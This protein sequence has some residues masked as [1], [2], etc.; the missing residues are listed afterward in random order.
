MNRLEELLLLW[1]DQSISETEL[2]ELK[3]LL[4]EPAARAQL[5]EDFMMTGVLVEALRTQ[6][7]AAST[8]SVPPRSRLRRWLLWGSAAAASLLAAVLLTQPERPSSPSVPFA[9]VE[10]VQGETFVV[11]KETSVPARA[12]QQLTP[13][14]GI[15]TEGQESEAVVKLEDDIRL[16]LSGDTTVFTSADTPD[17][18]ELGTH[19]AF[20][21]G[22]LLVEA[23]TARQRKLTVA[24][25]MGLAIAG[26]DETAMQFSDATGVV[27]VRGTIDFVHKNT[28]KKVRIHSGQ[29][30][31]ATADGEVYAAQ[32]FSEETNVWTTFPNQGFGVNAIPYAVTFAPEEDRLAAV[33]RAG[34]SGLRFGGLADEVKQVPGSTCVAFSH[35]GK[36]VASSDLGQILIYDAVSGALVKK[37]DAPVPRMRTSCLAFSPDG[38]KL[39]A[40][41]G[42]HHD[43]G[44]VELW[45]LAAGKLL[46]SVRGHP[47]GVTCLAFSPDGK[48]LASGSYDK[49]VVFWDPVNGAERDRLLM[50][51][52]LTVWALTFSPDSQTLAIATGAADFRFQVPGIIKLWDVAANKPRAVLQGHARAVTSVVFA[53]DGHSL[54]SG[55]ADTTVRLWD[56]DTYREYGMLK[57]HKAAIGFEAIALALSPDGNWLAT[58]SYDH[59]VKLWKTTWL[60]RASRIS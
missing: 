58:A 14:A 43:G 60:R 54:I 36:L 41:R 17:Q 37:L 13:G 15:R 24:T 19:L 38:K 8:D 44:H 18:A 28:G 47:L 3:Q 21:R 55:S 49:C 30:L 25:P 59:T 57:G 42:G 51:P 31:A 11:A 46:S 52:A 9:Q 5:A 10:L 50:V 2:V 32:F 26:S 12:G 53:P 16:R 23:P 7:A 33:A 22:D 56:L 39:A 6:R 1:E 40:G 45:D 29:Y 35:D 20:E 48:Q 27:V 4:A 34:R